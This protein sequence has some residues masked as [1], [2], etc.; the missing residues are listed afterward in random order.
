MLL[1]TFCR[2]RCVSYRFEELLVKATTFLGVE[3]Q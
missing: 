1:V 2:V 3:C